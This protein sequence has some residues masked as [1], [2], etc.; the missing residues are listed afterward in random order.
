MQA[1]SNATDITSSL[2]H[3]LPPQTSR[4]MISSDSSEEAAKASSRLSRSATAE[5]CTSTTQ[6][7]ETSQSSRASDG[8]DEGPGSASALA[9]KNQCISNEADND[10]TSEISDFS[11]LS[12]ESWQPVQGPIAWVQEQM[13]KGQSPHK[14]LED[15]VPSGTVIPEGLDPIML[16]KIIISIVSE[17]PKRKKLTDINTLD[18]VL[19]L[20]RNSKKIMVLTGA[21]VSV[22]CGIP[23]FRSR[24]GV[25]AR[26]AKDFPNLPDPQ[27][28]FDI[29]FFR[30]D[31][32]PFFKFAKEI[33]PGQFRPSLCHYFI[34]LL[35]EKGKLLRN[36]TQN[37]DT[38]EQVAG[39]QNVIQC[40]GSFATASCT[41]CG[42]K[43]ESDAIQEDIFNQ[44]IPHCPRCSPAVHNAV[45]K[46]DIVFFGES[47]PEHF[48]NQ[49]AADK[50]ECDLLI[51][52]GS[53]LKVRPVALIPNSLPAH[54]PQILINRERLHHF[55][56]DV[57]LLGNCD[58]IMAEL[59]RRL[60]PGWDHLATPGPPLDEVTMSSLPTPPISP[61]SIESRA[62]VCCKS[63]E[64]LSPSVTNRAAYINS[65]TNAEDEVEIST[66]EC[67]VSSAATSQK[68][69]SPSVEEDFAGNNEVVT[70]QSD[71]A[72]CKSHKA[73]HYKHSGKWTFSSSRN[74]LA[75]T[76]CVSPADHSC[77]PH[78]DHPTNSS[79]SSQEIE[80][81]VSACHKK[82][83]MYVPNK[84]SHSHHWQ[85]NSLS[86]HNH[87]SQE[88]QLGTLVHTTVEP[89]QH[90]AAL[91][92]DQLGSQQPKKAEKRT[93]DVSEF[94]EADSQ[95]EH[96][97]EVKRPRL[98]SHCEEVNGNE[99]DLVRSDSI[100]Q[101]G[102]LDDI[103]KMWCSKNRVSLAHRMAEHQVLYLPP[104]SY[105]FKGAEV[106]TD[107][108]SSD[109][110]DDDEEE[111]E[112]ANEESSASSEAEADQS[113]EISVEAAGGADSSGLATS[114]VDSPGADELSTLNESQNN[115]CLSMPDI[116]VDVAVDALSACQVSS[117]DDIKSF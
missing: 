88:Q 78:S 5:S 57:E 91:L 54:V 27:A 62:S 38:L 20:L 30:S 100:S 94:A 106:Y 109:S 7:N 82:D 36:Y 89:E 31:P 76:D 56:F 80:T 87:H 60:G 3:P 43:V 110:S 72:C 50:D 8:H 22:S 45:M 90:R 24:D 44:V 11:D 61:E 69:S 73:H 25:Y 99:I 112:D 108:E 103:R 96:C 117:T 86:Y 66:S 111:D 74:T 17:P 77:S 51:V 67:I 15:L 35:E 97:D 2:A 63:R 32:R 64:A 4:T 93:H 113:H 34:K 116:P 105:V 33:Y 59:C 55:N 48:H 101:D 40:H 29:H 1:T 16:W 13:R 71:S 95:G 53:S 49:M 75:L 39:I 23:D 104:S 92:L 114:E 107:S 47:L 9:V 68:A 18:D 70:S 52:I 41:V 65:L 19:R 102:S 21:G 28:M 85:T 84:K 6:V 58:G 14:I 79:C 42:Y 10:N 37:I 115:E 81:L 98:E 83:V 26:L 46:P 12:Q